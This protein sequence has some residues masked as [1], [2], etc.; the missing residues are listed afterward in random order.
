LG[1]LDSQSTVIRA[2]NNNHGIG[3]AEN[4]HYFWRDVV[5]VAKNSEHNIDPQSD[6]GSTRFKAWAYN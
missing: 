3:L 2:L 5:K 6:K 4:R 1:D